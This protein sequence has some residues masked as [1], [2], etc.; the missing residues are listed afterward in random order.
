[1]QIKEAVYS[2]AHR[3]TACSE[4][5][6]SDRNGLDRPTLATPLQFSA[7]SSFSS[8]QIIPSSSAIPGA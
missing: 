6:T 3:T 8:S 5:E 1:M 4:L 7:R 2:G